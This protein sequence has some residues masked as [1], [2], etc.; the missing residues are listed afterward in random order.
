MQDPHPR[1]TAD[2]GV[3]GESSVFEHKDIVRQ[4]GTHQ[5]KKKTVPNRTWSVFSISP[6]AQKLHTFLQEI[7]QDGEKQL[8]TISSYFPKAISTGISHGIRIDIISSIL[9][10]PV[11]AQLSLLSSLVVLRFEEKGKHS[12]FFSWCYCENLESRRCWTHHDHFRLEGCF[13]RLSIAETNA[14]K[15][16]ACLGSPPDFEAPVTHRSHSAPYTPDSI[17]LKL[18]ALAS[19]NVL[20]PWQ[21]LLTYPAK[22]EGWKRT[23]AMYSKRCK[24]MC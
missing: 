2:P 19:E 10:K 22:C 4:R 17:Y 12:F 5:E 24:T 11:L 13:Q 7:A 18:K 21:L 15:L 23:H 16:N 3:F 20:D 1:G 8:H 14:S 9:V 6:Q